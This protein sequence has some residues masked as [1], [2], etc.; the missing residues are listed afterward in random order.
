MLIARG[1]RPARNSPVVRT[2]MI[3]S[4]GGRIELVPLGGRGYSGASPIFGIVSAKVAIR[5]R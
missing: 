5:F 3:A 4:G 1:T 2:S